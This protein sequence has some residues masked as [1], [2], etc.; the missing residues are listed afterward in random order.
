MNNIKFILS[1]DEFFYSF[2]IGCFS[3]M[4]ELYP[5][6]KNIIWTT[7]WFSK[8]VQGGGPKWKLCKQDDVR[9]I[10]KYVKWFKTIKRNSSWKLTEKQLFNE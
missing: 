6:E 9:L 10:R 4:V 8:P 3:Y 7:Y 2:S 5:G 1:Q